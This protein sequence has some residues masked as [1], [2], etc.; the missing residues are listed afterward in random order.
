[1]RAIWI[2]CALCACGKS[3]NAIDKGAP[4]STSGVHKIKEVE[5]HLE[6][7]AK[8]A[9]AEFADTGKFPVGTSKLL[10]ENN[11][12]GQV[13]GGCCGAKSTGVSID[14]KCPVSKEWASDPVWKA[15]GFSID[16]QS[17]YRYK[18]ESADGNSFVA[19]AAGD[20]DCDQQDAVY[21]L[22]GTVVNGKP[23]VELVQPPPNVY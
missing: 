1:M 4:E 23:T 8:K 22:K 2:V 13:A 18:Y 10:P 11:A 17:N 20:L 9:K 12:D 15:L 21:T 16:E 6:A 5:P 7:I 14:N 3:D 19:T